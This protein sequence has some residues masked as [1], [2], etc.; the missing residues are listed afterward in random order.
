[1]QGLK[2]QLVQQVLQQMLHQQMWRQ[3]LLWQ[4][5]QSL[6]ATLQETL[7]QVVALVMWGFSS[8]SSNSAF[9]R[10]NR[11]AAE[12][13][14]CTIILVN[15]G[16]ENL[17]VEWRAALPPE[18]QAEQQQQKQQPAFPGSVVTGIVTASYAAFLLALSSLTVSQLHFVLKWVVLQQQH[19][20]Q[21]LQQSRQ[22]ADPRSFIS[23]KGETTSD[24]SA[25]AV[26]R[27][28][29]NAASARPATAAKCA[30]RVSS[31]GVAMRQP[32]QV[33]QQQKNEQRQH[34]LPHAPLVDERVHD[35][36]AVSRHFACVSQQPLH[37]QQQQ[38]QQQR[39]GRTGGQQPERCAVSV[40]SG[41]GSKSAPRIFAAAALLLPLFCLPATTPAEAAAVSTLAE[42]PA[43]RLVLAK[44]AAGAAAAEGERFCQAYG[45]LAAE[46]L[47]FAAAARS[48]RPSSAVVHNASAD[49]AGAPASTVAKGGQ[50]NSTEHSVLQAQQ[51]PQ[52]YSGKEQSAASA[53]SA[54]TAGGEAACEPW[55]SNGESPVCLLQFPLSAD[56][57]AAVALIAVLCI[58]GI[59][60]LMRISAGFI[61]G[62]Q[63]RLC[64][65]DYTLVRKVQC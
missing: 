51:K 27:L 5:Q 1:M 22:Q 61:K 40:L 46:S 11:Q 43:A 26:K 4:K 18:Q 8:N 6:K 62:C 2:Q 45:G 64:K 16:N 57:A 42:L 56:N 59:I 32:Q 48:T 63:C 41:S 17:F 38:K 14:F 9:T 30:A 24:A 31:V 25:K 49:S 36:A 65:G 20:R 44:T 19:Q 28:T 15:F 47:I 10:R 55:L 60:H 7:R 50:G 3:Q 12:G 23:I 39:Q 35:C 33:Q 34:Q 52:Q 37:E 54:A 29:T 53:H 21:Q 58:F 13:T